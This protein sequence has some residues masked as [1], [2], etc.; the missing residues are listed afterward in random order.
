MLD[1]IL[2]IVVGFFVSVFA[3]IPLIYLLYYFIFD[4]YLYHQV[5]KKVGQ[6]KEAVKRLIKHTGLIKDEAADWISHIILNNPNTNVSK[7]A[8]KIRSEGNEISND[9][10]FSLNLH[11]N[12]KLS[13]KYLAALTDQGKNNPLHGAE[14]ISRRYHNSKN[15]F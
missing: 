3:I 13:K 1:L 10:K 12:T 5:G 8:F 14:N 7:L 11:I 6:E 15:K 9:E 2:W 4:M